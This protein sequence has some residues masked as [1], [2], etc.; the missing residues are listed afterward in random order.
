MT[1]VQP[2]LLA[3][4]GPFMAFQRRLEAWTHNKAIQK[5]IENRRI[6]EDE[7]T[8]S[9]RFGSG[10][11]KRDAMVRKAFYSAISARI[12][13][14]AASWRADCAAGGVLSKHRCAARR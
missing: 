13:G 12:S 14:C 10:T 2:R 6:P 8:S 1:D 5:A 11:Q 3:L 4:H 7:R 9:A